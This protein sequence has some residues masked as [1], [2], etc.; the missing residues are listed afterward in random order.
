VATGGGALCTGPM[1]V[2]VQMMMQVI[3]MIVLMAI[4]IILYDN[5]EGVSREL[6]AGG[7]FAPTE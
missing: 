4:T 6:Q 7:G 2:I 3:M 1:S 5:D